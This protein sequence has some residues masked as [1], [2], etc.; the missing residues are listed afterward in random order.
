MKILLVHN[1]YLEKGGEDAVVQS[2]KEMLEHYGHKVILFWRS[3]QEINKFNLF[4]KI[5]FILKDIVW[6]QNIY[7]EIK[8]IIKE[9]KPDIAHFHNSF[10]LISPSAYQACYDLKIPIVQTLHNYRF[11]CPIGTMFRQGRTCEDCLKKGRRSLLKGKC[12]KNSYILSWGLKRLIDR[13]EHERILLKK[14]NTMIC[15]SQFSKSKYLQEKWP[16][17][18]IVVKPH[19][20][21][22][23]YMDRSDVGNYMLFV[24]RL[25][26]YKG[27]EV[28]FDALK[29][30]PNAHLRII[31][32]GPLRDSIQNETREM[33]N[34]DM[35]G[36]LPYDEV[37]KEIRKA[38]F[39]IF[40]S[41]CY[42][43]FGRS[44][45]DAFACGVPVIASDH[46]A[47]EELIEDGKNGFLF[48]SGNSHDLAEKIQKMIMDQ[49]LVEEMGDKARKTYDEKFTMQ[50][51][52]QRLIKIYSEITHEKAVHV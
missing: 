28:L 25:A 26:D 40:P 35:I 10:Y 52:Y 16:S 39:L 41:I 22:I 7:Q 3:N 27:I 21:D 34:V 11:L 13:Y 32:N 23:E 36:E 8:K 44:I 47:G 12:F 51:N 49:S 45:M 38:A 33:K 15:P 30:V 24:G 4:Q 1:S 42:E 17:E 19:F 37:V 2:E 48:Q 14:V 20:T 6:S 29:H 9:E 43:T 5:K 31:G 46:G 18:K 50:K